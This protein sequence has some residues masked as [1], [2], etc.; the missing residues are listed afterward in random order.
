MIDPTDRDTLEDLLTRYVLGE[1]RGSEARELEQLIAQRADLASELTRLQ[2]TFGLMPYAALA[3][4]PPHLRGRILEAARTAQA[5]GPAPATTAEPRRDRVVP[6]GAARMR[7]RGGAPWAKIVGSIAAM[8]IVVLGWDGY[9]LR[10]ELHL[11]RAVTTTLQEPNVVMS[12]A[13]RP[14]GVSFGGPAGNVILDLDAK[15]A[16]VAIRGLPPLEA[17]E[18]YRLWARVGDHAVPCG[19]FNA[20]AGGE[21]VSQF[22]IPVD[23]YTSPVSALFLNVEPAA[24]ADHPVGKTVMV[25]A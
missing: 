15:K 17:G 4:P 13:M 20:N 2:R 8:L 1:L 14:T 18:V 23:A 16:A 19:Q 7:T 12:F 3:E 6:I 9:R 5:A 24:Q 11:Q 10:Q 25:S 22:T 21:V